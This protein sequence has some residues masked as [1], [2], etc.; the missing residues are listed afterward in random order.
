[1]ISGKNHLNYKRMI[2]LNIMENRN[3]QTT[4]YVNN[5]LYLD[6]YFGW[7]SNRYF[8]F[9]FGCFLKQVQQELLSPEKKNVG[10]KEMLLSFDSLVDFFFFP[11]KQVFNSG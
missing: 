5:E 3:T 1:M 7:W 6:A 2:R 8:L 9:S 11:V 4:Q 10:K